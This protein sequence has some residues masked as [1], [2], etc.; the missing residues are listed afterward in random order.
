MKIAIIIL[1]FT[2]LFLKIV[3]R[4]TNG[5]QCCDDTKPLIIQKYFLT[6]GKKIIR[7]RLYAVL[8]LKSITDALFQS[9]TICFL[10]ASFLLRLL[11][12]F[13]TFPWRISKLFPS[14]NCVGISYVLICRMRGT[15]AFSVIWFNMDWTVK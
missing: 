7:L 13:T 5:S 8:S 11:H 4:V 9:L 2:R 15:R 3:S 1:I 12:F 14:Q 6:R 10:Y